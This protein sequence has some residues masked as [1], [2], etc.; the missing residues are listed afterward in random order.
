MGINRNNK[1]IETWNN[2]FIK[3]TFINDSS[4]SFKNELKSIKLFSKNTWFPNIHEIGYNYIVYEKCNGVNLQDRFFSSFSKEGFNDITKKILLILHQIYL[5][6]YSHC[7][8]NGS[9]F[10]Y[11]KEKNK[12]YF[13]DF[14][15]L[16][17]QE[18]SFDFFSSYD[19]IGNKSKTLIPPKDYRGR[20][21]H[22]YLT[23]HLRFCNGFKLNL[24]NL[25]KIW[26][27]KI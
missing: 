19:I 8:V 10:I 20:N 27:E 22:V 15:Y 25:K 16:Q 26:Y 18:E 1:K 4:L 24:E 11:N 23:K 14:E 3:K 21:V 17:K 9:N 13:F 7:D 6:G 2:N 5:M 12:L